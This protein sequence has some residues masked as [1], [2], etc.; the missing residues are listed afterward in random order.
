MHSGAGVLSTV[1]IKVSFDDQTE[2]LVIKIIY[3]CQ[4]S[5]V[6]S[7]LAIYQLTN[8]YLFLNVLIFSSH[9]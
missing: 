7:H 5:A 8:C 9:T 3:K 2:K 1:K 6:I 4:I